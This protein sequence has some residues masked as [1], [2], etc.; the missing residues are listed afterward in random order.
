[1]TK[2]RL[3][4]IHEFRDRHGKTRRY[5]R[6]PG[7]KRIPLK[8]APGTDAFMFAYHAA[9][10]GKREEIGAGR[11][12]PG[13]VNA[14][15]VSYYNSASYHMGAPAT[16]TTRRYFL[17]AFRREHGDKRI[18]LLQP[19]HIERMI[20]AKAGTPSAARN[21][22]A[23]LRA[24]MDHCAIAGLIA[25]DP[26]R[27][28]KRPTVKTDGYR[29]WTEDDI[30][31]FE[32]RHP[33]GKRERLALA[34]MLFTGQRR[35]DIIKMGRQHIRDGVLYVRQQKTGA[36]LAIP[37]HPQLVEIIEATPSDHLTFITT[38]SGKPFDSKSFGNWFRTACNE[39][40]LPNGISA[41]GLRKACCRR[42]AEAG[43]SANE[44]AAI[45]GHA[46]LRAITRYTAAADQLRMARSGI[47][48]MAAAFPPTRTS[49]GKP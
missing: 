18:A 13:T 36:S 23:A 15:V 27:D 25:T 46:S 6:L 14:A 37:L 10:A 48:A 8:G 9:L 19:T 38:A 12:M 28:V 2:I 17:E 44:I 43:R 3:S 29:T 41:H 34:L 40:G 35:G 24:L 1:M 5:V 11:T 49:G 45:S 33:I 4:Y 16:R 26:T 22:Y 30:A 20:A 31:A 42:L 47:D 7:G 21:F 39:A 32:A